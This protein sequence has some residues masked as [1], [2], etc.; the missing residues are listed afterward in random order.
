MTRALITGI[1]GQDGSYLAEFLLER[2]YEVFGL[3]RSTSI[4]TAERIEHL[5]GRVQL[6][7]GDMLDEGSLVRALNTAHPN[8]VY[9][10][11]AHS[12]VHRSFG[13]PVLTADVTGLGVARMLEAIRE[14]DLSVRFY[15]ASSSEMFGN[16]NQS[17]QNEGTLLVPA[18]PYAVAKVFGHLLTQSYRRAYGL[19]ACSGIL[20]NHE[21]P[22]RGLQF[23]TRK[24]TDGAARISLG[25]ADTLLLGNLDARR[26]WG[27][28]GDYVQAMWMM[29]QQDEPDDYVIASG[30]NHSVRTLCD[31]AFGLV[32]LDYREHVVV[33][34]AN[35]RPSDVAE[36]LGDSSKARSVLGWKPT[37][38][39]EGLVKM[40]IEADLARLRAQPDIQGQTSP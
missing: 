40:M 9:N 25:M 4:G 31:L 18:S 37:V 35:L 30:Q 6:I 5:L 14:T 3:V 24:V 39:F 28:A 33:D 22:R 21:S 27:Y 16:T 29:L 2:G 11:A 17:P 32:G 8:E 15:Q 36:L 19:F 34:E 20:F 7:D 10:L 13:Q 12:F 1:T 38:D 23:V 26:D